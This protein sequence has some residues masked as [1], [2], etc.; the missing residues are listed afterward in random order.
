M[1][2]FAH[3]P[4]T[5]RG[6]H[7]GRWLVA[8]VLAAW[9]LATLAPGLSRLGLHLWG[10]AGQSL[11]S[12][13][14]STWVQVC[15]DHGTDWV[16]LEG[17]DPTESFNPADPLAVLHACGH[18]DLALDRLASPVPHHAVPSALPLV[19]P[20]PIWVPVWVGWTSHSGTLAR[21]PPLLS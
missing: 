11:A 18:C 12:H 21:G 14:P 19:H 9:F 3:T 16:R 7:P 17:V 13:T 4:H 15:T 8:C 6:F 2:A 10:Q 20:L 5:S 1:L